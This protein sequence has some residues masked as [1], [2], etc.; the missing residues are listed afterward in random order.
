MLV[1]EWTFLSYLSL[2]TSVSASVSVVYYFDL[3]FCKSAL[4]KLNQL[5]SL[6]YIKWMGIELNKILFE[7]A[8]TTIIFNMLTLKL[9]VN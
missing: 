9:N 4:I 8:E 1:K 3:V 5:K 2:K 7:R 6:D